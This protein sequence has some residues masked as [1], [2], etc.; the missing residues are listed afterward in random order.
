MLL[1]QNISSVILRLPIDIFS[2]IFPL[3]HARK[4]D[5]YPLMVIST[6]QDVEFLGFQEN[7]TLLMMELNGS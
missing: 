3:F 7:R 4:S 5:N 2:L 1:E 6:V